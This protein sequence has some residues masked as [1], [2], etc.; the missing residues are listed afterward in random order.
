MQLANCFQLLF[1]GEMST[2]TNKAFSKIYKFDSEEHETCQLDSYNSKI[3]DFFL[4]GTKYQNF[5]DSTL[6][7]NLFVLDAIQLV[8]GRFHSE[9]RI[10]EH[11]HSDKMSH[12]CQRLARKDSLVSK[13][14]GNCFK[15]T[16]TSSSSFRI[17]V[18]RIPYVGS[19]IYLFVL[20][21][22]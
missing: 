18:F 6:C 4:I 17:K 2:V 9:T 16:D 7:M 19:F 10:D 12:N 14:D 15:V 22:L 8:L 1:Q 11:L 13:Y 21:S 3:F 5:L 20:L